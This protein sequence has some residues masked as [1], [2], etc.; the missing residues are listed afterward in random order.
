MREQ[1]LFQAADEHGVK[2]QPLAGVHGHE[3]HGV[4]S[5]LGLVVARLQRGVG[6]KG[7]QGRE[8]FAG[9]SV[10]DACGV[11]GVGGVGR[12]ERL[13][14]H[15]GIRVQALAD[16]TLRERLAV[17]IQRQGHGIA[18][19]AFLRDKALGGVDQFLQ[20]LDAVCAFFF[21]AEVLH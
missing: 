4:L 11:G 8:G 19:K 14:Q 12:F 9:V 20:V 21:G 10:D 3:L 18:A 1:A 17:L 5:G 13:V 2:L 6:E 15:R 16:G 7:D